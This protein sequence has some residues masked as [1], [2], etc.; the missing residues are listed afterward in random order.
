MHHYLP[1]LYFAV[2]ALCQM[3]DFASYR[4]DSLG[5]HRG[6]RQAIGVGFLALAIVSF[7]TYAPIT[8]ATPWSWES[9]NRFE[10]SKGWTIGC[11]KFKLEN[12][13]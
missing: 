3:Y 11:E 7:A 6:V 5:V 4:L 13:E 8:Y 10:L 12:S 2:M 1:A 9:C